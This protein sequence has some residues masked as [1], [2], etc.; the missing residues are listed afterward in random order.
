MVEENTNV[1]LNCRTSNSTDV[2]VF[3]FKDGHSLSP[4]AGLLDN[5]RTLVLVHVTK[6]DTGSYRCNASN[7]VS[8]PKSNL[9]NINVTCE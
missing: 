3:W 7:N 4:A 6:T 5:N 2:R 1:T 9:V 8:Q